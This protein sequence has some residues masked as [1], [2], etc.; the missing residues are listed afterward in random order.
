MQEVDRQ[1]LELGGVLL[2]LVQ[3]R[4]GSS[5]VVVLT[6]VLAQFLQVGQRDALR[7]VG[8]GL[9]LGP[10]GTG[11][12]LAQVAELLLLD[13]DTERGDVGAGHRRYTL[14]HGGLRRPA[15]PTRSGTATQGGR[16]RRQRRP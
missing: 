8:D 2:D 10:A 6:P 9:R 7:P 13:V 16:S 14:C 12:A 15:V 3:R 4:L 11:Q 1:A 5:P